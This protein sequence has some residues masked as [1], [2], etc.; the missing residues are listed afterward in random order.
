MAEKVPFNILLPKGKS[1]VPTSLSLCSHY[2]DSAQVQVVIIERFLFSS[3]NAAFW[4][5]ANKSL[6]SD[7][8]GFYSHLQVIKGLLISMSNTEK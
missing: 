2:V 6:A 1:V 7:D 4:C 3:P 8:H 5:G